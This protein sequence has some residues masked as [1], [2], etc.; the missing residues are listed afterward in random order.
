MEY[1]IHLRRSQDLNLVGYCDANWASD[2]DDR[3]QMT[4]GK[5]LDHVFF[6]ALISFLGSLK[7]SI[8]CLDRA[9]KLSTGVWLIWL[10]KLCG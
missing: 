10:L 8:L 6:L 4:E 7:S 9:Q 1:G 3:I 2:L 5:H